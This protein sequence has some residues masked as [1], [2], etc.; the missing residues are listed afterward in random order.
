MTFT[1]PDDGNATRTIA[2]GARWP[3]SAESAGRSLNDV[4]VLELSGL[5]AGSGQAEQA[6]CFLHDCLPLAERTLRKLVFGLAQASR[7]CRS[8]FA[9]ALAAEG[10]T[11]PPADHGTIAALFDAIRPDICGR[12]A[13][14]WSVLGIRVLV[15]LQSAALTLRLRAI[16]TAECARLL[17]S[18]ALHDT[19]LHWS[20]SWHSYEKLL[21][22]HEGEFRAR[23][24][25]A[26]LAASPTLW[27]CA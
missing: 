23:A 1:R 22:A 18:D 11:L 17:G 8:S 12:A 5:V 10:V 27:H 24:Y 13:Q 2:S 25:A 26:H 3:A 16:D 20:A 4:L 19:L 6:G 15:L 7:A 9:P 14:P 21:F